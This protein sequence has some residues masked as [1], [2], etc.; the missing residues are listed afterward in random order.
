MPFRDLIGHR[1]SLGL[2]ARAVSGNS[3]PPSLIFGGPDGIGKRQVALAV[4]Q[5][6][7][8]LSPVSP[9]PWPAPDAAPPLAM[10]A[11]GEC[12]VCRRIAR[13]VHPDVTII[14]PGETGSIKI[15]AVREVVRAVGFKPF[16][17]KRRVV[18]FES[19]DGL[20]VDSQDALLKTL[21]EPPPGSVIILVA[22]QPGQ[23]LP[24]VRSRCPQVRF[25]PLAA[26][27]VAA[28]LVRHEGLSESDAR[29]VAAVARGSLTAAREA[30]TE[31]AG[32]ASY[33]SAAHRALERIV[34]AR[35]P[36]DRLA[37][38]SEIVGKS[39]ST[40][41]GERDALANHLHAMAALLRDLAVLTT[42]ADDSA[43]VNVDL[44]P[45]L[46]AL[47]ADFDAG[48]T[49]RAF[50]AVDGALGALERNASPKIVADWLVLQ[51]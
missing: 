14:A 19:A 48:R 12:S 9:A 25:A 16:E 22:T 42:R 11:C 44:A 35:D 40:G 4:A 32:A 30:A 28:W 43:V 51:L 1:R 49:V 46:R 26:A 17:A 8:C 18:I 41:A 7:N 2:L 20:L 34:D 45:A 3:L 33:R 39:R 15:D 47:S 6:L 24:T 5:A 21:E 31:A 29:A 10:D 23:L 37:V 38:T 50:T 27:D 36:R 13:L